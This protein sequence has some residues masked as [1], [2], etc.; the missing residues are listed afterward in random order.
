MS[1]VRNYQKLNHEDCMDSGIFEIENSRNRKIDGYSDNVVTEVITTKVTSL[2]PRG[3]YSSTG[4][5]SRRQVVTGGAGTEGTITSYNSTQGRGTSGGYSR[6]RF[7]SSTLSISPDTTLERK[8]FVSRNGGYEGSSSGNSSPEF[9]RKEFST[10]NTRGRSQ[11]RESAIRARLQSASPSGRWTELD[12]VKRL[13]K[14]SRSASISP[15]RTATNTLPY[16]K[17]AV[18]E[19][20]MVSAST[21]SVSG[22]YD[23]AILN[24]ALPAYIWTTS[25]PAGGSNIG[26]TE[27][28]NNLSSAGTQVFNTTGSTSL[29]ANEIQNNKATSS[30][31]GTVGVT[32]STVQGVQ[33]NL[34]ATSSL[35]TSP[36]QTQTNSSSAVGMQKN[37]VLN[38][39]GVTMGQTSSTVGSTG[40]DDILQKD[41]KFL[42]LEKE[43]T[44]PKKDTELLI[45]TKDS[46]KLFTA[47]PATFTASTT[48]DT[49]KKETLGMSSTAPRLKGQTNGGLNMAT[50]DKATYAEIR[51]SEENVGSLPSWCSCCRCC[52]WWKWLLGLLLAW[53]LLLG[54][55]LGLI[56]LAEEVRK[57]KSRVSELESRPTFGKLISDDANIPKK[58]SDNELGTAAGG[59]ETKIEHNLWNRIKNK[60]DTPEY[61]ESVRGRQGSPGIKGEQG[62]PG[63][64]GPMGPHGAPGHDGQRG[65][66][67]NTGEPGEKGAKGASGDS[68]SFAKGERGEP[69]LP[70]PPGLP[71]MKGAS[72]P[73]GPQGPPGSSGFK[74]DIGH[75]GPKGEKGLSGIPGPKG[76]MGERGSRGL[77][78]E[79]GPRGQ[80]GVA[81]EPGQKGSTGSQGADGHRGL[82][83]E[84]GVRGL[85]GLPGTAGPP[86]QPGAPGKVINYGGSNGKP[87]VQGPPGP[88][89][90]PGAPG[91][92]GESIAGPPGP[93]GPAGPKGASV[94]GPRG[95]P[96]LPGA[97]GIPGPRLPGPAGPPGPPGPRGEAGQPGLPGASGRGDSYIPGPP[98]PPGPPGLPGRKGDRGDRGDVGIPGAPGIPGRSSRV[99]STE[100]GLQGP[101][102]PPG[103]PGPQGPPGESGSTSRTNVRQTVMEYLQTDGVRRSIVGPPGPPGPPGPKGDR[104]AIERQEYSEISNKVIDY[105]RSS[106]VGFG[107]RGPPGPPGPPGTMSTADL[108]L[109]LQNED[110]QRY[111]RGPQGPPG[112]P[113]PRGDGMSRAELEAYITDYTRSWAAGSGRPGPPGPPGVPGT[114]GTISLSGDL[115]VMLQDENVRRYLMGPPGPP[116]PPGRPGYSASEGTTNVRLN[117]EDIATRVRDYMRS[118]GMSFGVQGPP[119][120]PGS[121]GTVSSTELMALLQTAPFRRILGQPGPPG[122][123]GLPGPAGPPGLGGGNFRIE[124]VVSYIQNSGYSIAGPQGPPGPP[125]PPGSPG[126]GGGLYP[127]DRQQMKSEII[128][129]FSSDRMRPYITG[130]AGPPGPPGRIV[131]S[132]VAPRLAQYMKDNGLIDTRTIIIG[133][134]GRHRVFWQDGTDR[135]KTELEEYLRDYG[136]DLGSV[137]G[138]QGNV[139][140]EGGNTR[141]VHTSH[142]SSQ[143]SGV[144]GA[145][146]RFV[147]DWE[148]AFNGN[149]TAYEKY[150]RENGWTVYRSP[151]SR[152]SG[153]SGVL[154]DNWE[155]FFNGNRTAY[156]EYLRGFGAHS[157]ASGGGATRTGGASRS[158]HTSSSFSNQADG[159]GTHRVSETSHSSSSQS[160]AS[161]SS[162]SS[163][164]VWHDGTYRSDAELEEM[165][166]EKLGESYATWLSHAN[167]RMQSDQKER[168]R[169]S[170]GWSSHRRTRRRAHGLK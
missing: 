14:G 115:S 106:G 94:E 54:L 24:A 78:G 7:P 107:A 64:P 35:V 67:G 120:P 68:A 28:R 137:N 13:L 139:Q 57:L 98:G 163:G 9:S 118:S 62:F 52:T 124:D 25:V 8:T 12:D 58:E 22:R 86:G 60:L 161:S 150:L 11:S 104:G 19:T 117:Y 30:V 37:L 79:P 36:T 16:P 160:S 128:E 81:G 119:G 125:G 89:G 169:K 53:L 20:K 159:S 127:E 29:M 31:T 132:D 85:P 26:V 21:Q 144:P 55:L 157:A 10:S 102:G 56:A 1:G 100:G 123:R 66:K 82:R 130:P 61:Q 147:F 142:S 45:M 73:V 2:P 5:S 40:T 84:P 134:S 145:S 74:G 170:T 33:N 50:K 116:G 75:P 114:P 148:N 162:H 32:T 101:P 133:G 90:P 126:T 105:M 80:P 23:T 129:Y 42:L 108:N 136:V 164:G 167:L 153:T 168:R 43:N 15:P 87:V 38:S 140:G 109:Y 63:I 77:Q 154:E 59:S 47:S 70:G 112:A 166:K 158:H 18:V 17:K 95:P 121:P 71:G 135:N 93:P 76:D 138:G 155:K 165:L 96:G 91:Q 110:I 88:P 6:T 69:G 151:G 34:T 44:P 113:G 39:S 141:S 46:G 41:Y 51:S 48:D 103:P 122:P 65:P 156:E 111:L 143:P 3:T 4:S 27:Y 99:T 146:G 49:L 83:G 97:A 131:Y 152:E 92:S 149:R 72:G